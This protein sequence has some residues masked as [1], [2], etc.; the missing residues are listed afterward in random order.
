MIGAMLCCLAMPLFDRL[1]V[2]DPVGASAVHGV[3]GIWG[4][5]ALG[6][7]ADNPIPLD[8]TKNRSGLFKGGG[9]YL[10]GIQT[11]SAFCLTCWGI[12]TTFLLL[13]VIN[14]IIPIRMDPNE[15]L[16]GADLMEHRIRHSQIGLSRAISALAP[17]KID[18]KDIAGI[19]P[20]GLN[21]GHEKSLDELRA[22]DDK[23]ELWRTF[24][25]EI[26]DN[27]KFC[28]TAKGDVYFQIDINGDIE[29][30]TIK[31]GLYVPSL[32]KGKSFIKGYIIQDNG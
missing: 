13:F 25:K 32:C 29:I 7:F 27:S 1:G 21:P 17:L 18:L 31:N 20:V 10:V 11:L 15:E 30:L 26:A 2:D 24:L 12:C 8:T 9:W 14:K 28:A 23:L 19:Q 4:V 5:I 3:C 16:L 22:A 6:F